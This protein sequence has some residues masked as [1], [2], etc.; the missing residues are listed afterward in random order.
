M[1]KSIKYLVLF[2]F[3]I[4]ACV[5]VG[6]VLFS[7]GHGK[8]QSVD[9]KSYPKELISL[10]KY[11]KNEFKLDTNESIYDL[12][13]R[14]CAKVYGKK[15]TFSKENFNIYLNEVKA[16]KYSKDTILLDKKIDSL[17]IIINEYLPCKECHDSISIYYYLYDY[18]NKKQY[19]DRKKKYKIN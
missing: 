9:L 19:Y 1:K 18:A 5:I 8:A 16:P 13:E 17:A 10:E 15:D 12:K 2:I 7:I 3:I 11:A 6:G 4:G 14:G